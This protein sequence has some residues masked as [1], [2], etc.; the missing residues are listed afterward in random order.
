M[1]I[2]HLPWVIVDV[3][4]TVESLEEDEKLAGRCVLLVKGYGVLDSVST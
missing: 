2:A 3:G 4:V 1:F